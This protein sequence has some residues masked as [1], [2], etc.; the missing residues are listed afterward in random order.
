MSVACALKAE[1]LALILRITR[2]AS[3]RYGRS[4]RGCIK[5]PKERRNLPKTWRARGLGGI[6]DGR[7][8]KQSKAAGTL[9]DRELSCVAQL[10]EWSLR[11]V[12]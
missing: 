3:L 11:R 7:A 12:D 8:N 9:W 2:Q 1:G 4:T 5:Y 6:S 10:I